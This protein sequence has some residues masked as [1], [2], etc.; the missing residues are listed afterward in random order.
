MDFQSHD[1]SSDPRYV[2]KPLYKAMQVLKIV[3]ETPTSLTLKDITELS[4]IPKSTVYRYLYTMQKQ[5]MIAYN[6]KEETYSP[7]SGLWWL[8]QTADPFANLRQIGRRER[9]KL[10]NRFNETVNLGVLT[11]S[12][13][14]YLEVL[15]SDRSIRMQAQKGKHDDVHCTALGKALLAFRPRSQWVAL[16]S[17]KMSRQTDNTIVVRSCLFSNL[18]QVRRDGYAV[19]HGENET[20]ATCIAAPILDHNGASV[21][22]IS[23]TLPTN[24]TSD[25]LVSEIV[26]AVIDTCQRIQSRL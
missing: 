11:G 17:D 24:R 21:A 25:D 16:L 1:I 2:V 20:G 3:C 7:G 5:D 18:E 10:M 19:E 14:L 8:M 26:T 22:S 13:I 6:T 15:E 23:V 12:Q 4:G 9:R